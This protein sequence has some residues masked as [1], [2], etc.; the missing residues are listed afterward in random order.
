MDLFN[1]Y[2]ERLA[3]LG[4]DYEVDTSFADVEKDLREIADTYEEEPEEI[5]QLLR[6]ARAPLQ[7]PIYNLTIYY[8]IS[9]RGEIL[10]TPAVYAS[11]RPI[12]PADLIDSINAFYRIPLNQ[13]NIDAY[14]RID[15][16]YNDL[17]EPILRAPIMG[18]PT[19]R[20]VVSGYPSALRPYQDG[21][22]LVL[23][24]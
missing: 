23:A 20:D 12:T 22:L 18:G 13:A 11:P 7:P 6:E 2:L 9:R 16:R 17:N 5:T 3:E 10:P 14:I 1:R 21:Y 24:S 19:L 8:P 15:P 4:V